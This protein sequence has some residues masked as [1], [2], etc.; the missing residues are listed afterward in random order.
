M[1][2]MYSML[3]YNGGEQNEN[4]MYAKDSTN[5]YKVDLPPL[6]GGERLSCLLL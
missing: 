3:I 1:E 5:T 4:Y 2:T 6:I